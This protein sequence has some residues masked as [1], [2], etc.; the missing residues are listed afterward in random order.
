MGELHLEI[1]EG[2]IRDEKGVQVKTSNPIV[3]YR[4]TVLKNSGPTEGKSPNRHNAFYLQVEPLDE[5][6]AQAIEKGE[7]NDGRIKKDK[8]DENLLKTLL[9]LGVSHDEARQYRDIY[10]GNIFLDK[11]KGEVHIGEVI[12][13]ILDSF[14]M[15]M[16]AGPLSREPC[17]RLKVSLVDMKLHEDAI[18][19]GP[20]Q[21]YPAIRESLQFAF[22]NASPVLFEPTQI[23]VIEI[24]TE[25]M[26]EVSKLITQKR[27]QMIDARQE[28]IVSFIKA[29]LPVGEMIGWSSDL[30]S[31]TGGRGISSLLDQTFEKMPNE[32]QQKIIK[33]IRDRKGLQENQ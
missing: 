11:T 6:V 25:F 33:Q 26:G 30:R 8:K 5:A 10:L 21:V 19:R 4:E 16:K 20:A 2:R 31:C 17:Q 22:K 12:E 13:L 1:V 28:G 9:S 18:H 24:P 3:V 15:V 32:L 29:K 14:E 23:H 27:G 7:I